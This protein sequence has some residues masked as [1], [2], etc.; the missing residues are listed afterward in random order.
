MLV[1]ITLIFYVTHYYINYFNH[2]NPL[3]GPFP[4]PFFGNLPQLYI[5][6]GGN[7]KKFFNYNQ[8]KYGDIFEVTLSARI[9]VLNRSEYIE[10]LLSAATKNPHLAKMTEES[11]KGFRELGV[12]GKGL[13][14]NQDFKLW[15]YNR[16]FFTR[17]ILSPKFSHEAT[18]WINK[19]FKD[20]ESYMD[21]LYI[22]GDNKKVVD[23]S[24]WTNQFTND[25]VISLLTG[26]CSYTMAGYF[27]ELSNNEKAEH[28]SALIDETINFVHAIRKFIMG[29]LMFQIVSPFLRH[30]FPYF[31][32]KSDDMMQN[33]EYLNQRF[34][35]IIKKRR[36]IIENTPLDKPLSNDM[37]TSII[38][39]NT[40]RDFNYKNVNNDTRPMTNPEI[41]GIIFD[42]IV[43]GTDTTVNTILY[44]IY[45][46]AHNHDVKKKM[47]EE[48][49]SVF[50]D[51]NTRPITE[52]DYHK[53]QYCEAIVKE[54]SRMHTIP[55]KK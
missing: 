53:L 37:L 11:G 3:P 40:P 2:I 55:Y 27:N 13:I 43:A 30:Y 32:N 19:F 41:R 34:D 29:F 15:R 31:K 1:G 35:S 48:I 38:V 46:L 23:F 6:H 52:E 45:S 22:N 8:K 44:I 9:I 33:M 36:K 7:F 42:G 24:T 25:T 5:G 10:K 51:N 47:L 12:A 26:E 54:V 39:A 16:Q 50:Q 17:A 4:F 28:S 20:L 18:H 49:D 21:K 14:F